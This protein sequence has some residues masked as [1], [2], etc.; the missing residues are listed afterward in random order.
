MRQARTGDTVRIHYTGTLEDGTQFASNVDNEP[1]EFQLGSG[2][3]IRGLDKAILGM[4]VGD[5][6]ALNIPPQ[7][8]FGFRHEDMVQEVPRSVLPHDLTPA[9][10]MGLEAK[11][12][13][14]QVV[15]LLIT[16]VGKETMTV[17]ANHPL[18][19]KVLCMDIEVVEIA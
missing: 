15:N 8:A 4:A 2:R 6:K 13:K 10:G 14:G 7:D 3:G 1:M 19:G 18:A 11:S 16:A 17:D 9:V 5:K 12:P